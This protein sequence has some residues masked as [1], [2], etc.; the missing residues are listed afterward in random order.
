MFYSNTSPIITDC[1]AVNLVKISIISYSKSQ[2]NPI[3]RPMVLRIAFE[4][5]T[6]SGKQIIQG[7]WAFLDL[8]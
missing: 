4:R 3:A 1:E 7:I 5:L 8:W 6:E 2:A